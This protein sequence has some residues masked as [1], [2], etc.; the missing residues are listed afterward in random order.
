VQAHDED[1]VLAAQK[2]RPQ[3]GG[4][5]FAQVHQQLRQLRLHS[6]HGFRHQG[7]ASAV[8]EAEAHPASLA[9]L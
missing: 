6:K 4:N 5:V 3:H 8:L 9:S 1:V 2:A 7:Q